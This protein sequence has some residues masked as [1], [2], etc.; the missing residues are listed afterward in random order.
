M[1][2]REQAEFSAF[3]ARLDDLCHRAERGEVAASAFLTPRELHYAEGYLQQRGASYAAFGGY[4]EA[5]RKR[6]YL[7]P[8][9]MGEPSENAALSTFFADFGME[10]D[11]VT[12]R[13][14]GSG[15]RTLTHRDFLGAILGLG[16]ERSVLGDLVADT[17][18]GRWAVVFCDRGIAP[19]L[20]QEL[21]KVAN[22]KVRT[23]LCDEW[24]LPTRRFVS[25]RD[26]VAS[27]RLDCVIA[28]LC[29][30]SREKAR[31]TVCGGLVEIDFESEER[32]DRTVDSC[33]QISV[34]G[35]GRFRIVA[36]S[37]HTKKGRLRLEAEKY[38]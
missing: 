23:R 22:D 17:E 7:L 25:I 1:N 33:G 13:I 9:Y 8:E 3:Y 10:S 28:A 16:I 5:E 29:G 26:T 32:P 4:G 18:E 38:V 15:Y 30:L 35:Y 34:R 36:L 31:E 37:E 2:P 11:I 21:T 24:Q 14:D 27:A 12:L 19:F 6:V 20:E